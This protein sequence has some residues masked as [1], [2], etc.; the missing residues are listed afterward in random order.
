MDGN[1]SARRWI[2]LLS[3]LALVALTGSTTGL[4]SQALAPQ[5]LRCP[6]RTLPDP[7][8]RWRWQ[9]QWEVLDSY[10]F[11]GPP[12]DDG[13]WAVALDASCNLYV[14]D[15]QNNQ[16]VK[17]SPDGDVLAR[18]PTPH[19]SLGES[20]SPRGVAVDAQ[21]NVY[22]S[23][24]PRNHVLKLD[25]AGNVVATWGACTPSAEN[26]FCDPTQPGLFVDPQGIAVD[27]SGAVYV[28]EVAGNRI[29]K[30]TS[31]GQ[32]IAVWE[33]RGRA[34]GDLWILGSPALDLDGNLY[35]PDEYNNRVLK[36]SPDGALLAQ[37]GGGPDASP[38]PGRFH[39]PR[40]VAV[41][42][43]G[44]I[45]VS[46]RDNW[47]VQKLAPDGTFIDQ[48]RHCLDA[49]SC[50]FPDAGDGPGEF[51]AARGLSV[52]G[53]GN[54]YVADTANKRVQRLIAVAVPVPDDQL[55]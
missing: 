13:P 47:R 22:V 10:A 15:A 44:N 21:G 29:Q 30:L 7:P 1:F 35:V 8:E 17:L 54:L 53:Q 20:S 49:P 52:D 41:D 55:P 25:P 31:D 26:R 14:A 24:S 37:I 16:V 34:P 46:D 2:A 19:G 18:W 33:M 32:P 11:P 9:W 38:E 23:D 40:G 27:G 3:S 4:A 5:A 48:W 28:V 43:A 36:F 39:G 45:Y 51:F 42:Q 12:G 6:G 50:Q